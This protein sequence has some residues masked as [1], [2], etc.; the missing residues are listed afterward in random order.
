MNALA[1]TR[2]RVVSAQFPCGA[3]WLANALLELGIP[4]EELWGFS[5]APEW[6]AQDDGS[7]CYSAEH[8][9]WQ[10]TLAA[11][12]PGRRMRFR[13]RPILQFSHAFPWQLPDPMPT[14]LMV[15]DPRD[16]LY[17]EWH[18]QQDNLGLPA[19]LGFPAF[20]R[21]SF[22]GGPASHADAL[23]LHLAAWLVAPRAR[24]EDLLVIRFEDCKRAPERVLRALLGWLGADASDTEFA[25]AIASSDV[26]RLQRVEA[27]LHARGASSRRFN[28]RGMAEEWRSVWAPGWLE[29]MSPAWGVL[30]G[31]MGYACASGPIVD[32]DVTWLDATLAWLGLVPQASQ[33]DWLGAFR[34]LRC[35]GG[36]GDG[37]MPAVWMGVR[38]PG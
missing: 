10:Q 13:P 16:A 36:L 7:V 34:R 35:G 26:R 1:R 11:L 2:V 14:V 21:A 15:R 18:R 33:P 24:P 6:T 8:R 27:T 19:D 32:A 3:A 12:Y 23:W 22:E 25:R 29:Q 37:P 31:A 4:I 9:P 20:M 30:L 38:H 28:R 5:T 17:S